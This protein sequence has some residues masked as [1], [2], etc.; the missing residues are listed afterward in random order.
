[1]V[2]AAPLLVDC[3]ESGVLRVRLN[4]PER[5]N[6]L[7]RGLVAE[8]TRVFKAP[9]ERVVVLGSTSPRAFCAGIDRTLSDGDRARVSDQLYELYEQM[10]RS[11]SVI[12]AALDGHV[13]GGGAQLALASDI[14]VA[15]PETAI[16]FAGPGHG[17]AVGAWGLASL[18]GRGRALE[19]C[20]SDRPVPVE[21]ALRI[22]LVDRV[23]TETGGDVEELAREISSLDPEAAT[24]CKA[25]VRAA[26]PV[27]D[28]LRLEREANRGWS[29]NLEG[30][31]LPAEP[32]R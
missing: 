9:S 15:G 11:R 30:P 7:D 4:R 25:I 2:C 26:L 14:R 21:E 10:V 18:V 32:V 6:A 16:R 5:R 17:L 3:P 8:L 31:G 13:V 1:M 23:G 12:I 20:L 28:A 22:G 29:G 24:R 19:L 27:G